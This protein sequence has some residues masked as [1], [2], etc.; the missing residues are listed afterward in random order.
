[1]VRSHTCRQKP[2]ARMRHPPQVPEPPGRIH[3]RL[4]EGGELGRNLEAIQHREA[5]EPL[6][7]GADPPRRTPYVGAPGNSPCTRGRTTYTI[8]RIHTSEC[9]R[10]PRLPRPARADR[11]WPTATAVGERQ[12]LTA[13]PASAGD[14]VAYRLFMSPL[15]GFVSCTASSSHGCRHGPHSPAATRLASAPFTS[16]WCGLASRMRARGFEDQ[17]RGPATQVRATLAYNLV[18]VAATLL[19]H[20]A[21]S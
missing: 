8:G 20:V 21:A 7:G 16:A 15:P 11:L 13:Q 17:S 5:S 1:M 4:V 18:G 12:L 6:M 10:R 2:S 3:H 14:R 9:L 19:S